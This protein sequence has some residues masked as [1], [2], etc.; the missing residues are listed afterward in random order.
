MGKSYEP[1]DGMY[2]FA[3]VVATVGGL[4]YFVWWHVILA[5]IREL[6]QQPGR[7]GWTNR[8]RWHDSGQEFLTEVTAA[9]NGLGISILKL[10][11]SLDGDSST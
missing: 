5:I 1:S 6:N 2:L 10:M 4:A 11:A 3:L 8:E 9:G 7:A